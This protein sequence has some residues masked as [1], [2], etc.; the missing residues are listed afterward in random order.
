MHAN[1]FISSDALPCD[2]RLFFHP[3]ELHDVIHIFDKEQFTFADMAVAA[4]I[5]TS[6][7]QAKKNGWLQEPIPLGFNFRKAGKKR[8]WWFNSMDNILD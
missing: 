3:L 1:I 7:S 6:K 2:E 8:V 4:G 5:F